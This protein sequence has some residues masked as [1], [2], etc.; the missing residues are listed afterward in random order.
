VLHDHLSFGDGDGFGRNTAA[1]ESPAQLTVGAHSEVATHAYASAG[2]Y[3]LRL[4]VLAGD[5]C[6]AG[7]GPS[8]APAAPEFRAGSIEAACI[9]V[10]TVATGAG[11][12][13]FPT[14]SLLPI[15]PIVDP[16]CQVRS[17]CSTASLPR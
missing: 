11:C 10:G 17:D 8:G 4:S 12:S 14:D 1:C 3:K 7:L 13:P 2:T 9:A 15:S 16:F 6:G 5:V